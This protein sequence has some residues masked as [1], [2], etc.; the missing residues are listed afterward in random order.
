MLALSTRFLTADR[1]RSKRTK[2]TPNPKSYASLDAAP[3]T[4]ND[5]HTT[6]KRSLGH[7]E[8][9]PHGTII[10]SRRV[11]SVVPMVTAKLTLKRKPASYIGVE[12]D[13]R[14]AGA[15]APARTCANAPR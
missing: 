1:H 6:T 14:A 4:S 13:E 11:S 8:R 2:R 15:D 7:P 12:R 3:G 9:D 10:P 5:M